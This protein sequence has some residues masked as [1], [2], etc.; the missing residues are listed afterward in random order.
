MFELFFMSDSNFYL[1]CKHIKGPKEYND[2]VNYTNCKLVTQLIEIIRRR[3][4]LNMRSPSAVI[5]LFYSN[6]EE[7]SFNLSV[8]ELILNLKKFPESSQYILVELANDSESSTPI[9]DLTWNLVK[10]SRPIEYTASENVT[11][12]PLEL[13]E[14][15]G[16]TE[17]F[18][19]SEDI[20]LYRRQNF[21]D[22]H[23]FI[24]SEIMRDNNIGWINGCYKSGKSMTLLSYMQT[25][26]LNNWQVLW[27]NGIKDSLHISIL[28]TN[29]VKKLHTNPKVV[30]E[31]FIDS[32]LA[33]SAKNQMVVFDGYCESYE[34]HVELKRKLYQWHRI[35]TGER[36]LVIA[37][38]TQ[39]PHE[40]LVEKR[41]QRINN[42]ALFTIL[43]WSNEDFEQA[44]NDSTF[45]GSLN[46]GL[47]KESL[48]KRFFKCGGSPYW[49]FSLHP[50]ELEE[51]FSQIESSIFGKNQDLDSCLKIVG[52]REGKH[53]FIISEYFRE[54]AIEKIALGELPRYG[55]PLP[56]SF[57]QRVFT[58]NP[59][60]NFPV[61]LTIG[62]DFLED[63]GMPHNSVPSIFYC[64]QSFRKLCESLKLEVFQNGSIGWLLGPPGV[65]KSLSALVF[66][67]TIDREAWTIIWLS[68][69]RSGAPMVWVIEN[70]EKRSISFKTGSKDYLNDIMN[71]LNSFKKEKQKVLFVDG[72]VESKHSDILSVGMDWIK[73]KRNIHKLIINCSMPSRDKR[74]VEAKRHNYADF[75]VYSWQMEEYLDVI[76][77]PEFR[78][79]LASSLA[80]LSGHDLAT[81]KKYIEDKHSHAG[82]SSRAMFDLTVSGVEEHLQEA[83]DKMI[84]PS[85]HS[86][87]SVGISSNN[88]VDR[89]FGCYEHDKRPVLVSRYASYLMQ[90]K[91]GPE[92]I[93]SLVQSIRDQS[94]Y[95]LDGWLFELLLFSRLRKSG[96]TLSPKEGGDD[97][98]IPVSN[99]SIFDPED[100]PKVSI[101][102]W[103]QPRMFNQGGYDALFID[104][105]NY[106][107]QIYQIASGQSH[108]F[109]IELFAKLLGQIRISNRS[110][111]SKL[112]KIRLEVIF[113]VDLLRLQTFRIGTIT[114]KGQ[115]DDYEGW[116]ENK[117]MRNIKIVGMNC[118]WSGPL[119]PQKRAKRI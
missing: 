5:S 48:K 9:G 79:K 54:L 14:T 76:K 83:V 59:A 70:D 82:G 28:S 116:D 114:G 24:S 26:D 110:L 91:L 81:V 30:P 56:W 73:N 57:P 100:F 4:Q 98:I 106:T 17:H 117:K 113:V 51:E 101:P 109:K 61:Y 8:E 38:S 37:A 58:K 62:T 31:N 27:I 78:I 1:W 68:L 102:Q 65:G 41:T 63:T 39:S 96:L 46:N 107:I 67:T 90:V 55:L 94:N 42:L 23:N 22:C 118:S 105:G 112:K 10:F 16:Y 13:L 52:I 103:F 29:G 21:Q 3:Q 104:P 85:G 43:S 87:G 119:A 7:I 99:V 93:E 32:V 18:G 66:A 72:Y 15:L 11:Y 53:L 40:K 77:I 71:V 36:R 111:F 84:N 35:E 89:I 34:G 74:N 97:I 12:I 44:V 45:I 60:S 86:D 6:R 50:D 47:T 92:V 20:G 25:I 80:D 88:V 95:S 2:M 19:P 108:D 49:M 115:L 33:I 69:T 75:N 64:R